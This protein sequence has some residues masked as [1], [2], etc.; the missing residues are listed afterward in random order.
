MK[1]K[2]VNELVDNQLKRRADLIP[3]VVATVKSYAEH[4]SEVYSNIAAAKKKN[5]I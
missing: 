4:E 5:Y 1:K 3:N 2:R